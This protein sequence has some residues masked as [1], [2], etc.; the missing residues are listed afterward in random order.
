MTFSGY[1]FLR[2]KPK[3]QIKKLC[4]THVDAKNLFK[5]PDYGYYCSYVAF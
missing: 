1:F 4:R 3:S 2:G 5:V